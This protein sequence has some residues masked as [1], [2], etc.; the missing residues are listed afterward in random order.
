MQGS[1][2][3][4]GS[5]L[6]EQLKKSQLSMRKAA[7]LCGIDPATISRMA[8]GKQ[9]PRPDHLQKLANILHVPVLDLW[10]AAGYAG[11][12]EQEEGLGWRVTNLEAAQKILPTMEFTSLIGNFLDVASIAHELKKYEDYARTEEGRNTIER[13]FQSKIEQVNGVGPFIEKLHT[14][15]A[16]FMD[17]GTDMGK[18]ALLGSALLYFILATDIIPDYTFPLGYLDDGVAID[19]VWAQL[20]N[21]GK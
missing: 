2:N 14:M 3:T 13:N 18:K 7:D 6:R 5:Y 4:F 10:T 15:Y 1:V 9:R 8:N 20:E 17:D 21:W 11:E 16:L 12:V 19:M